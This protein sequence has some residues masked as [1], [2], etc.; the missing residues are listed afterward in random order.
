MK[1]I[2]LA[3]AALFLV[4]GCSTVER[5]VAVMPEAFLRI[6]PRLLKEQT[7]FASRGYLTLT[8]AELLLEYS[9]LSVAYTQCYNDN[10][11]LTDLIKQ[12]LTPK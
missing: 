9:L 1:A 5:K 11:A 10:K 2:A 12:E 7:K 8:E 6:D 3:L 4:S